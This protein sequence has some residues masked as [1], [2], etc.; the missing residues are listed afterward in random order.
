MS[1]EKNGMVL[2]CTDAQIAKA[3]DNLHKRAA[4]LCAD[5]NAFSQTLGAI[6]PESVKAFVDPDAVKRSVALVTAGKGEVVKMLADDNGHKRL[7][8][9]RTIATLPGSFGVRAVLSVLSEDEIAKMA[10]GK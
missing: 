3:T 8:A 5:H 2:L 7:L 1:T 10:A 6:L 4:K 9:R